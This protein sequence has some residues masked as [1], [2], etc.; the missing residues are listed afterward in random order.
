MFYSFRSLWNKLNVG[1]VTMCR[2]LHLYTFSRGDWKS[3]PITVLVLG[4]DCFSIF[5]FLS[6]LPSI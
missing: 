2:F 3:N 1:L 6:S 5:S 4:N